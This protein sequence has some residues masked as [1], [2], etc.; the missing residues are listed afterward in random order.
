MAEHAE[1][2]LLVDNNGEGWVA[3]AKGLIYV[4]VLGLLVICFNKRVT[5]MELPPSS[6]DNPQ[7]EP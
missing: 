5:V 4:L 2:N 7:N 6:S 1:I 3:M